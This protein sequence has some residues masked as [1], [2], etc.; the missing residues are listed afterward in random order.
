MAEKYKNALGSIISIY[1]F[2]S[3]IVLIK[4]SAKIMGVALAEKIVLVI[5][6][7]T[8]AVFAG[9]IA[10]ALLHSSGAFDSI[11]VAFTSSGVMPL[12]LAVAA[13]IGAEVGTTVTPFLISVIERMKGEH[14][15]EASFTVTMSHVLYNL[16]TLAI[17]YP[18]ELFFGVFTN[19]ATQG[20]NVFVKMPWLNA[21]PDLLDVVTP[22]VD[23]LL[24]YIPPWSG[25]VL[26]ALILILALGAV[27]K[28]M[29]AIF[30]MPR[31]WNL[32]RSTFTRPKRAFIAGFLFTLLVPSTTV[33]VSL[34]VPLA[35]SGVIKADYYIL[36][37]IL[38]ANIGTVFDVMIAALAT[39][40]PIGLG[41]WLV[42]LSINLIGA[43]IFMPLLKP[44]TAFTRRVARFVSS[45]PR[46]TLIIT[47]IF[48][49]LPAAIILYYYMS[50]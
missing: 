20:S 44:F 5:R 38:G 18:L 36:P 10:T 17:F 19:I 2:V 48:H 21:V 24:D 13:I 49:I 39:G 50:M 33:M 40:D 3:A 7:T 31:S 4:S 28:Y 47:A 45:S 16:V 11:V 46:V 9:W 25:I 1:L 30:S 29:I 6:D 22:W 23:P 26:G 8:S 14:E 42:H 32:I 34:L 27:E 41:V 43:L 35:T 37:Y 15:S 12:N